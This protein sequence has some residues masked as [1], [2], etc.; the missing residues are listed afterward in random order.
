MKISLKEST[1]GEFSTSSR[2]EL[3][4]KAEL[5]MRAA[6]IKAA[7]LPPEVFNKHRGGEME[8]IEELTQQMADIYRER[9][10]ALAKA[11]DDKLHEVLEEGLTP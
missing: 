4:A 6:L 2:E 8:V 10:A 5:G 3:I 1:P 9:T 7:G 11:L